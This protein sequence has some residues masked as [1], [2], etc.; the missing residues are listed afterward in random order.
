VAAFP[1]LINR[2]LAQ[3]NVRYDEEKRIKTIDAAGSWLFEVLEYPGKEPLSLFRV[4]RDGEY[5]FVLLQRGLGSVSESWY[6][7]KGEAFGFYEYGVSENPGGR[8]RNIR[9]I[10]GSGEEETIRFFDSNFLLTGIKGPGGNY[11]VN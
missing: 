3:I 11:S 5:S 1:F 10:D 4:L 8:I 9:R 7:E 6:D 2:E